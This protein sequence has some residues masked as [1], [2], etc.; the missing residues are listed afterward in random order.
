MPAAASGENAA[1]AAIPG[2][3]SD[4][5]K[6]AAGMSRSDQDAMARGMV[7]RLAQRLAAQPNDFDGWVRLMRA[8]MVLSDT[9]GAGDALAGARRAFGGNSA[10]L[11]RLNEAARTLNVPG[12]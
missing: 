4:Q 6:D 12:A 5:I 9:K 3:S 1:R 7:D 8:R 11:A 2:P 10:A